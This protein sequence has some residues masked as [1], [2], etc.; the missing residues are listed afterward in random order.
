[1]R[2][3]RGLMLLI[4]GLLFCTNLFAQKYETIENDPMK[5]RIYT[6]DN[7]L[8]VYMSVNKSEPRI[9][10]YIAVRVGSKNDPKETT[11]LAHYFE[12]MM[13]K[14]TTN[15]GT[16]NWT[17]EQKYISQ[18]ENLYEV[19]RQE[20]DKEKRTALYKQIDSLSYIASGFAIANEY[21][22]MMSF[23]GSK[24]TNAATSNDY[25]FYQE[26]IPSNQLENWA[27][28][29]AD[30]FSNPVLRLFHTEL[31]TIYEEKNMSLTNEARKV[32][33]EMLKALFPS[34]PYGQQTTLGE[35]EHLR[36][37]SLKNIREFHAKYYVPN[38]YC[39]AMSGD[40][41]PDKA[42]KVIEK[43]FGKLKSS[44]LTPFEFTYEP[45]QTNIKEVEVKGVEA[46]YITIA[47]RINAGSTSR[48]ALLAEMIDWV[49]NNGSTGLIDK[50]VNQKYLLARANSGVYGL[51]DYT[52]FLLQAYP[53]AGQSLEE[54]KDIMLQQIEILK[55]GNWD[56]SILKAA[57]NNLKLQEIRSLENNSS[58][59][60]KMAR[61]YMANENWADQVNK[62]EIMSSITKDEIVAFAN[63]TFKNNNYVIVRKTQ[64]EPAEIEK[65]EKPPITPIQINREAE[66]KFFTNIKFQQVKPIEAEFVN[67]SEDLMIGK[68]ENGSQ[69]LYVRNNDNSRYSLTFCY[70]VGTWE[71]KY[72]QL[73]GN[74]QK[75]LY[76]PFQTQEQIQEKLFNLATN[77]SIRANGKETI[78]SIEGLTENLPD[79]L[80]VIED[81][82]TNP[83]IDEKIV[84]DLKAQL[85]KNRKD[86]KNKQS[87]CF[88][89]LSSYALLGEKGAHR[90]L[91]S[92]KEIEKLT[93]DKLC[94]Q[95]KN[96]KLYPEQIR[97]YG[98]MTVEALQA[99]LEKNHK[100]EAKPTKTATQKPTEIPTIGKDRVYFVDYPAKQ[101]YCRM[102]IVT[103]KYNEEER[104]VADMYNAYFGGSMNSIVFQ[105]MR[106]K[107]SLAYQASSRYVLGSEPGMKDYNFAHIATQNDKVI[108]AFETFNM[109]L[110]SMPEA[111]A[112]FNLAKQSTLN[113]LRTQRIKGQSIISSFLNDRLYAR[114]SNSRQKYYTALQGINFDNIKEFNRKKFHKAHRTYVVLGNKEQVDMEALKKFGKVKELTLEEIFGY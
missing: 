56:E 53:K 63:K 21:D 79:A 55:K 101:S 3:I 1:M 62:M 5:V 17:E 42:I 58:R 82:L 72:L 6:L 52:G 105:E 104:A 74:Y 27:K 71:N 40:F 54:A 33:E 47:Y 59:A 73:L 39:I 38:N 11:G 97:Y 76:T 12:H 86:A 67:Y 18:I 64:G 109:L 24:G 107:R 35:A 30:R 110:D 90:T 103:D 20:T 114:P 37:P 84:E 85:L 81:L 89:A 80:E 2:K 106:E 8:K 102:F 93:A 29:Q 61:S 113:N 98:D 23:I 65:V 14:G 78:V 48:E 4:V 45:E 50:N 43:Y 91:L 19:Y 111:Q 112:N 69:L 13:F 77:F 66:S 31:E 51:N 70:K 9:Q 88:S 26:N 60:M 57:I 34:H 108:E 10:T 22:K 15:F 49:L 87:S 25:T 99:F 100:M 92:D 68:M 7:G 44:P 46:P 36:N 83:M 94:N 16:T 32:R 28:I 95:I 96:L 75:Y 41:D